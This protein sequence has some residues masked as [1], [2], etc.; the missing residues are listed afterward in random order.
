VAGA[1]RGVA[2]GHPKKKEKGKF[3]GLLMMV[4]SMGFEVVV[5]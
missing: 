5:E 3:R 2:A 1:G 4:E